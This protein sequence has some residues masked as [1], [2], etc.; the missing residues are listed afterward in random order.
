MTRKLGEDL[1]ILAGQG[2]ERAPPRRAPPGPQPRRLLP[3]GHPAGASASPPH[4]HALGL[5]LG[6]ADPRRGQEWGAAWRGLGVSSRSG[7][8]GPR[9]EG[10]SDLPGG[11]FLG[12][13]AGRR[14]AGH[15]SS[16]ARHRGLSLAATVRQGGRQPAQ[17]LTSLRPTDGPGPQKP[18]SLTKT[19]SRARGSPGPVVLPP[20]ERLRGSTGEPGEQTTGMGH[21]PAPSRY[22][23]AGL[24]QPTQVGD[25]AFPQACQARGGETRPSNGSSEGRQ[26]ARVT[27]LPSGGWGW[28]RPAEPHRQAERDS[29]QRPPGTRGDSVVRGP[30]TPAPKSEGLSPGPTVETLRTRSRGQRGPRSAATVPAA[31]IFSDRPAA[32]NVPR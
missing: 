29:L 4:W 23:A 7:D 31:A 5:P 21:R 16:P 20:R 24:R 9:T 12:R 8:Q 11:R 26:P 3:T 13:A 18:R 2:P 15:T 6:R 1:E 32:Q 19:R 22:L 25:P 28:G 14:A 10:K 27:G 17:L 30:R